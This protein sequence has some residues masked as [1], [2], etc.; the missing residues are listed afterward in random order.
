MYISV[1]HH[2][3]YPWSRSGRETRSG[4][5]GLWKGR[6]GNSS[7]TRKLTESLGHTTGGL[8]RTSETK[9]TTRHELELLAERVLT[10]RPSPHP[11]S[12]RV[13]L[14]M[15]HFI[16]PS[17]PQTPQLHPSHSPRTIAK[18]PVKALHKVQK[19]I[20]KKKGRNASIH[21]HSRD[22]KRL[23][24]ASGRQDKIAKVVSARQKVNRPHCKLF[25]PTSSRNWVLTHPQCTAF[26]SS[27]RRRA[28]APPLSP[29]PKSKT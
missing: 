18:M 11:G 25:F 15:P 20:I 27:R 26:P 19:H 29:S 2:L 14:H 13:F 4:K 10:R 22:S 23:Q 3:I 21:E 17:R 9:V 12:L 6:H 24:R 8:S 16:F 5:K 7:E 1:K 28:I